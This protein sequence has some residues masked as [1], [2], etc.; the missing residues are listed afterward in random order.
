VL[1]AV[2]QI[3]A[4]SAERYRA[5]AAARP[6]KIRTRWK[7]STTGIAGRCTRSFC[8]SCNKPAT[9]KRCCRTFFCSS[10]A[11]RTGTTPHAGPWVRA[12]DDGAPP[13]ARPAAAQAQRSSA[14]R[15]T[16]RFRDMICSA[17]N[18]E[19]LA[20]QESRRRPAFASV[21]G[22]IAR[23]GAARDRARLF[24]RHDHSE[25]AD[26]CPEPL[27][28]VKTGSATDCLR[29]RQELEAAS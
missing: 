10:G 22:R 16:T 2:V 14:G 21:A 17:P 26:P 13:G 9:R 1:F 3:W 15:K 24:L 19:A 28:T 4:R 23:P 11:T 27:G 29:L 8:E 7:P 18:P 6:T 5:D 25:I 20:Q 12:A